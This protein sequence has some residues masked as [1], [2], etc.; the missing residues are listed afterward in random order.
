MLGCPGL[1]MALARAVAG[2]R[3][4]GGLEGIWGPESRLG[5]DI[6][7]S[8]WVVRLQRPMELG[9]LLQLLPQGLLQLHPG[10]PLPEAEAAGRPHPRAG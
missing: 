10:E 5:A 9:S 3:R 8:L 4:Q 6:L 1:T 7:E 2:L